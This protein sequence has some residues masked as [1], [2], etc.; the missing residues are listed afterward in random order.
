MWVWILFS[1]HN[2]KLHSKTACCAYLCYLSLIFKFVWWSETLK[3]GKH[4]KKLKIRKGANTFS[5]H[6]IYSRKFT[7][8]LHGTWSLLNVLMIFGIKEKSII[9]THAMYFWLLLQIY[10]SDLILVLWSR[11]TNIKHI[12]FCSIIR[13][14]LQLENTINIKIL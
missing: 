8:Y 14:T 11:V 12:C 10:P 1:L 7:K 3:C 4:A 2:K 5:H 6:C 13:K 9:L